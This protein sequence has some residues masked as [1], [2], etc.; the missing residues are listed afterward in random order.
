V[1]DI[2]AL[3]SSP[4]AI[5][6]AALFGAIWG[7]FLN[8]AI[9]RVPQGKSVI[10]PGSHCFA[11]GRPVRGW[12]N[13]PILSYFVLRGRCRACGAAFSA[14]YALVEALT[15][16]LSAVLYWKFV[17][18]ATTAIG[19]GADVALAVRLARFGLYF[20][21]TAALIV[22]SFIDFD[23]K[24]L[25]DV[26]T[27]P[28]IVIL[29]FA[30]FAVHQVPWTERAIG[31]VAGYLFVFLVSEGYYRAF[32]REGLGLGDGKLLAMVGAV[33]GWKALPFV[34][35][36]GSFIGTVVSVPLLLWARRRRP[37]AP[38]DDPEAHVAALRLVEIP[39]GPYLSLGA[40]VYLLF[41][42]AVWRLARDV[43]L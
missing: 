43:L 23:T 15:A 30:A 25:P 18:A 11:C 41:A 10:R 32:K 21:F 19:S 9:A 14:R 24:T 5:A 31:A 17:G 27:L 38:S 28:A 1:A 26:I 42:D 2:D 34:L 16:L 40:V 29:F 4:A 22:L 13:I 8:V 39:F 35:F 20:A 7:S 6:A 36:A 37:A 12:D 33:F 3:V